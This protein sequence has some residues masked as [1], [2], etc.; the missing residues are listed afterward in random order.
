M[1]QKPA[2][3]QAIPP[4]SFRYPPDEIQK[5]S[6]IVNSAPFVRKVLDAM[7]E[8]VAVITPNRQVVAANQA[9]LIFLEV[10]PGEFI[11]GSRPGELLGCI[12]SNISEHGCGGSKF[13]S[14]CGALNTMLLSISKGEKA[15]GECS[16]TYNNN[17]VCKSLELYLWCAPFEVQGEPLSILAG[18]DVSDKKRRQA[19]EEV[20]FHDILNTMQVILGSLELLADGGDLRPEI[21]L[22]TLLTAA[23]SLTEEIAAQ[24]DL[25]RAEKGEL[26]VK[27]RTVVA[28]QFLD[29]MAL[30]FNNWK[31]T[32][33]VITVYECDERT[34]LVIDPILLKRVLGNMLKNALEASGSNEEV[35]LGCRRVGGQVEFWV[36]N[37]LP[38]PEDVQLRIFQRSFSTKS[39]GRGQG[40]YCMRL[41]GERYLNGAVDFWSN[42]QDGTRF[43]ARFP[44]KYS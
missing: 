22:K 25:S 28:R 18:V 36:H 42:P 9:M 13:C 14:Q 34:D 19:L 7:P 44:M 2:E 24:R 27:P 39:K 5:Y 12:N 15:T 43:F 35:K 32:R 17:G 8:L 41:L 21:L 20:F 31:G 33:R 30:L 23:N 38:M 37:N 40:T 10:A 1:I 4:V 3:G 26:K 29:E 6:R 16:L 11:P